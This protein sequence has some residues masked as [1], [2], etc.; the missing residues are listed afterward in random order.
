MENRS[1]ELTARPDQEKKMYETRLPYEI[2]EL[3]EILKKS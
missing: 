2:S 3:L 1:G